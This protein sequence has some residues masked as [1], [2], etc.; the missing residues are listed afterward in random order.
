MP[1]E[2]AESNFKNRITATAYPCVERA[3]IVWTY[4]GTRDAAPPLP[5]IEPTLLPEGEYW[6]YAVQRECNWLQ[7]LEGDIDTVH[8]G[9]LH[10]GHRRLEDAVP[11]SMAYYGVADRT[12]RYKVVTTDYGAMYGAYRPAG[13]GELYWRIAQFLFPFWVQTPSGMLGH[14]IHS[15]A[16]VPMDDHH[17]LVFVTS[18]NQRN[19]DMTTAAPGDPLSP[20]TLLPNTTDWFGRFRYSQTAANDYLID[21]ERQRSLQSFT[22][23]PGRSPYSEDQAV[24]ESMGAILDRSIEHLGSSDV[25]VAEVRQLLLAATNALVEH[26][27]VPASVDSP[28]CYGVRAG[29]VILPAALDWLE[30]IKGLLPAFVE[31]PEL[32]LSQEFGLSS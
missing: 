30:G 11:G 17:T 24:T 20:S 7:G 2:P 15:K 12:P 6:T 26:S 14:K 10:G 4:M 28:A 5:D 18:A 23:I 25:M 16:W 9:F 3:G 29:A 21:R 22:G 13:P 31:H 8:V 1:N 27:E 32:D 19:V